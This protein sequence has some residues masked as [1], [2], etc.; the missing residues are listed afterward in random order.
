[1]AKADLD[2]NFREFL[3]S[4]NSAKVRYL[5]IGGYAVNFHGHHRYT[6]DLDV[7]VATDEANAASLSHVLQEFAGFPAKRVAP[8]KL[9]EPGAVFMFGREPVRIDILNSPSG[10][11]FE[12]C[13][14]R[15]VSVTL[16]GVMV[17]VISLADLR[18]NKKAAGRYADLDDLANLPEQ[19]LWPRP[20]KK[21]SKK[22]R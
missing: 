1:M 6:K 17:P 18:A 11:T 16:D 15:R 20:A 21:P 14:E 8:Y 22:K 5:L 2:P 7:W 3:R 4:L 12:A 13:W 9:R 10:V 19:P